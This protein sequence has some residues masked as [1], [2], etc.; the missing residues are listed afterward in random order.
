[1][2]R[3]RDD[4]TQSGGAADDDGAH[5]LWG[6]GFGGDDG[7]SGS[8][9]GGK[10]GGSKKPARGPSIK[11]SD[12]VR[13]VDSSAL[14]LADA[15]NATGEVRQ[16]RACRAGYFID[17]NS[18]LTDLIAELVRKYQFAVNITELIEEA[19][20]LGED[21]RDAVREATGQDIGEW[22]RE[23]IKHHF[24]C[25]MTD[26][27]MFLLKEVNELRA[28]LS[29]VKDHLF[30]TDPKTKHVHVDKDN[31]KLVA[32]IQTQITK[33]LTTAPEKATSYNPKLMIHSQYR[34]AA[35]RR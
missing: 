1:M 8:G 28:M 3:V 34:K 12:A 4:E 13:Q 2:K 22:T 30:Y 16:C 27:G 17:G 5:N 32:L 26:F 29:V 20:M 23:D 18:Q 11:F 35:P 10:E 21:D 24:F 15:T 6:V 31:I 33:L 7:E 9:R 25:C 14:V 19:Y